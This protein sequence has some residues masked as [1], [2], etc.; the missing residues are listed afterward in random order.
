MRRPSSDSF[1]VVLVLPA[2]AY[3]GRYDNDEHVRDLSQLGGERFHAYCPYAGGPA[4]GPT[5]YRY[6]PIYLHAK[7]AVVDDEWL[8]VGSANL[9]RRGLATDSEMNVQSIAPTVARALRIRLWAEHLGLPEEEVEKA[10]PIDVIDSAW[11]AAATKLE[12]L[13]RAGS[14]PDAAQVRRYVPGRNPPSRLLDIIQ[15]ATLEH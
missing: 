6:H 1:R 7:V 12:R 5:G 9:N 10:D 4:I 13:I 3:T 8:S 14:P 2:R 15:G 11:P